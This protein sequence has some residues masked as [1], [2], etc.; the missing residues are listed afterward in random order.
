MF[1][2]QRRYANSSLH[3]DGTYIQGDER[4]HCRR[5]RKGNIMTVTKKINIEK[6]KEK[7]K[8]RKVTEK[9][10]GG[11]WKYGDPIHTTFIRCVPVP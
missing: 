2:Q 8:N 9:W 11:V 7:I 6:V 1:R 5:Y 10:N 4:K 3:H